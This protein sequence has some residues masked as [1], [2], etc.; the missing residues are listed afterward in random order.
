MPFFIPLNG[1]KPHTCYQTT[2][3][4]YNIL[5]SVCWLLFVLPSVTPLKSRIFYCNKFF[6]F[7]NAS[8]LASH[9][10]TLNSECQGRY[11][12]T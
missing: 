2:H 1:D 5:V 7:P 11:K 6:C 3:E 9:P 12:M 10:H 4:K 8:Q